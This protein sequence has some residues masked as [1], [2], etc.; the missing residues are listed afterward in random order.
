MPTAMFVDGSLSPTP[1]HLET[2]F[3]NF[4]GTGFAE[5]FS[6]EAMFL[7]IDGDRNARITLD[8]W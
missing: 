1:T 5:K 8:E 3:Q 6:A 2:L 4:W 7:E